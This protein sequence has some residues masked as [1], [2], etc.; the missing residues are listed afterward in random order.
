[1]YIIIIIN[2]FFFFFFFFFLLLLLLLLFYEFN[3]L[4][5]YFIYLDSVIYI[6]KDDLLKS[7]G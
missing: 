1:M 4:S 5:I 6:F 2:I 7:Y 3:Y